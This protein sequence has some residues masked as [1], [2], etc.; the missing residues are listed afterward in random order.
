MYFVYLLQK[1]MRKQSTCRKS[2]LSPAC[3]GKQRRERAKKRKN[4]RKVV[5]DSWKQKR[6]KVRHT[7]T[8][9]WS[10]RRCLRTYMWRGYSHRVYTNLLHFLAKIL[11]EISF[12]RLALAAMLENVI[13]SWPLASR[14]VQQVRDWVF[15]RWCHGGLTWYLVIMYETAA[16]EPKRELWRWYLSC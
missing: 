6:T 3:F 2:F 1:V 11:K 9:I 13:I 12:G 5:Q 7:T 16:R 4:K 15:T 14:L 8:E 10:G